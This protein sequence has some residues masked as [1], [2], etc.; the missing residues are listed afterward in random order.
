M[1]PADS[2][3]TLNRQVSYTWSDSTLAMRKRCTFLLEVAYYIVHL[4]SLAA[5]IVAAAYPERW[6]MVVA[7]VLTSFALALQGK[8]HSERKRLAA[9]HR[10]SHRHQDPLSI[11]SQPITYSLSLAPL[12]SSLRIL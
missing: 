3:S 1:Q 12:L 9:Q 6:M 5:Q 8:L 10:S 11:D 7:A 2:A 4:A